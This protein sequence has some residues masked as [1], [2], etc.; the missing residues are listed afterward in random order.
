MARRL[1]AHLALVLAVALGLVALLGVAG[2]ARAEWLR[3]E[4]EHFIVYGDTSEGSLRRYAQKVERFDALLRAYYPIE[5]E[6]ET[7]KLEIFL[8]NGRRDMNRIWPGIS[9]SI[10]GYYS[11]NSG[12]IH[13]VVD[14]RIPIGDVIIFH[15]YAHHFMFQM[16]SNAYPSWF[17]EGF[18]EY[19][20]TADVSGGRV[21]FGRHEPNRIGALNLGANTWARMEDVL[22]WRVTASGRYPAYLYYAQAWAMTHY[23]MSTPE[24]TQMLG[25]YLAAVVRGEDSVVA[26][27]AA[28]GRTPEQLQN[29]VRRYVSGPINVLT[30]QISLPDPEVAITRLTRAEAEAVWLVIRLDTTPVIEPPVDDDGR[31]NK[32]DAQKAR[33]ARERAEH[34]AELIR[35]SLALAERHRG[36]RMGLLLAARAHRLAQRPDLALETLRPVIDDNLTDAD[37]LRVAAEALLDQTRGETDPEAA[38]ELRRRASGYL[39]RAMDARPMDFRIYMG[40]HEA[41]RGQVRYPTDNDITTLE[42]ANAL[43]PQAF[44]T[45]LRLGEAYMA[46]DMNAQAIIV[47]LPV[48]NSPHRSSYTRRAREMINQ[49]RAALGQAAEDFGEAPDEA[50]DDAERP[51][52]QAPAG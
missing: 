9:G 36:D 37:I 23:F 30:P 35:S 27:Q 12:R 20:A 47:L 10:G 34:R 42:V 44:E 21:Q 19:Y 16:R 43:A 25:R 26:M 17:V 22:K 28:T 52:F 7:P 31:T 6:Y 11:S 5:T 3:A 14:T 15:E 39:A 24:R 1:S 46:R 38:Q 33:E 48:S 51:A 2:P 40:L 4:T 41:R 18:A 8:A 13:A 29:D 32:S 45:R 50:G 49:A